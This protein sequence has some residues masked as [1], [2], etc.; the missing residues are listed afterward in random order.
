MTQISITRRDAFLA[1]AGLALVTAAPTPGLAQASA[2][3][4]P[5]EARSIAKE[6][7][8]WGMHPVARKAWRKDRS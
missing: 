4:S 6:V 8:L 7:F 1:S 5:D 3:L 2:P